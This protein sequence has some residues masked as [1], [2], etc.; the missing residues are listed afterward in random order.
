M[1]ERDAFVNAPTITAVLQ[2]IPPTLE[3]VRA[4][5]EEFYPR[6]FRLGFTSRWNQNRSSQRTK[7]TGCSNSIRAFASGIKPE[8]S[9]IDHASD[10]C[11][12]VINTSSGAHVKILD[13]QVYHNHSGKTS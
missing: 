13:G 9:S 10:L 1:F 2:S 8:Y 11:V 12:Q 3:S 6:R 4:H 5:K 7:L